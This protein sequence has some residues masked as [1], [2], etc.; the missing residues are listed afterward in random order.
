[1][2]HVITECQ[3]FAMPIYRKP[4]FE[5]VGGGGI[6]IFLQAFVQLGHSKAVTGTGIKVCVRCGGAVWW[7]T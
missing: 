6:V 7:V 5:H 2:E 3:P 4:Y 1:M